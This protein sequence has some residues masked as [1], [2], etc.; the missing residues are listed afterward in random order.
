MKMCFKLPLN[1]L[2]SVALRFRPVSVIS[3]SLRGVTWVHV[4]LVGSCTC[5]EIFDMFPLKPSH[6]L[7]DRYAANISI[8]LLAVM[9]M[10][11]YKISP[12]INT[13]S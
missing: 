12:A 1:F 8:C 13:S 5:I 2:V 6:K 11:K 3:R 7:I 4:L 10:I 9:M